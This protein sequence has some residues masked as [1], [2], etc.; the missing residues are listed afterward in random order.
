MSKGFSG[1]SANSKFNFNFK[2]PT[3]ANSNAPSTN[4]GKLF[5]FNKGNSA[6]N[7]SGATNKI[8]ATPNA[9]AA[10]AKSVTQSM[11]GAP[12]VSTAGTPF[13]PVPVNIQE[14]NGETKQGNAMSIFANEKFKQYSPLELRVFDYINQKKVDQLQAPPAPTASAPEQASSTTSSL[15]SA[16]PAISTTPAIGT[17]LTKQYTSTTAEADGLTEKE[18]QDATNIPKTIP[19]KVHT[20]AEFF[21]PNLPKLKK[22]QFS[23]I[24]IRYNEQAQFT[25]YSLLFKSQN[26]SSHRIKS[27][28]TPII[29]T[30]K[31]LKSGIEQESS[32]AR[33]A[34]NYNDDNDSNNHLTEKDYFPPSASNI[35]STDEYT[36]YPP[37]R[38][39]QTFSS[40][41]NFR[42]SKD[43]IASIDFLSPVDISNFNFK[44]D[45][46][47]RQCL[48]DVYRLKKK[49]PKKGTG[50]NVD[51]MINMHSAWPKNV[52]SGVREKTANVKALSQYED[53]LKNYCESKNAK[54]VF[55]LKE[56]GIFQFIVPDFANGPFDLP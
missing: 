3:G 49:L 14:K 38:K 6:T 9:S 15:F 42:I 50:L 7:P 46:I 44:K 13:A 35:I 43:T 31:M 54:F 28:V 5:N 37:L 30:A 23:D 34:P 11:S 26:S 24:S 32:T 20:A 40:I 18:I 1:F 4:S 19:A 2:N 16:K 41:K 22:T 10:A 48:V 33:F 12:Q 55:Y 52:T 45:V 27:F 8:N 51:A 25:D 36:I 39:I 56:K 17:N 53:Q 47:I 21:E 29:I